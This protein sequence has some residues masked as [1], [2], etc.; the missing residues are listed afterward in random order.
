MSLGHAGEPSLL[1]RLI[2]KTCTLVV[3]SRR[4]NL[5]LARFLVSGASSGCFVLDLDGLYSSN[6]E[7]LLQGI[8]QS[9]LENVRIM[10]PE[11]GSNVESDLSTVI[12]SSAKLV[13]IDSLNTLNHLLSVGGRSARG[14]KLT[15][16]MEAIAVF[17]RL[18]QTAV[19]FTMYA[20]ERTTS[21]PSGR[22]L[23]TVSD[24]EVTAQ[25]KEGK[26]R[27]ICERGNLWKPGLLT[28]PS[29]F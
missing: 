14:R 27:L 26:V 18:N 10:L 6:A 5:A 29:D 4:T 25:T 3:E 15:F 28:I 2:G 19:I 9:L 22:A 7:R 21:L 23:N 13:I 1:D 11:P 8:P 24:A 20:R 12:G 16:F 17:A